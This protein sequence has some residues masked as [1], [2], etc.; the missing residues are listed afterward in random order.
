[1]A[2]TPS[3]KEVLADA[4]PSGPFVLEVANN[5]ELRRMAALLGYQLAKT[6]LPSWKH[7]EEDGFYIF[8]WV[9]G[10]LEAAEELT[11][12]YDWSLVA[13]SEV[14]R[15][16]GG[17]LIREV[18]ED[19][20]G[21]IALEHPECLCPVPEDWMPAL[22]LIDADGHSLFTLNDAWDDQQMRDM[23]PAEAN[24]NVEAALMAHQW[25][26]PS[27]L[28]DCDHDD[29]DYDPLEVAIFFVPG[30]PDKV[31]VI[32]S[33]IDSYGR[34]PHWLL[35]PKLIS[36][37][38]LEYILGAV[39]KKVEAAEKE[40]ENKDVHRRAAK[41]ITG[42]M[43]GRFSSQ[44]NFSNP[45][46]C[47]DAA[48]AMAYSSRMLRAANK[49][50]VKDELISAGIKPIGLNKQLSTP[51]LCPRCAEQSHEEPCPSCGYPGM[52]STED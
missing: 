23:V 20:D 47:D 41:T 8:R 33:P 31:Q 2:A 14:D 38:E 37:G 21:Y 5:P 40:K 6:E 34:P 18:S 36:W 49:A 4:P 3:L 19:E 27:I 26:T 13:A 17:C 24:H 35:E 11:D 29:P 12:K 25:V 16:G 15:V 50:E 48:D 1:M 28:Y 51:R 30:L 32:E 9:P 39:H 10:C 52:K 44:G 43:T 46:G 42:T 22:D 7:V 45:S